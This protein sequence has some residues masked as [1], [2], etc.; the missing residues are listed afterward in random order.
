[1]GQSFL[2]DL[3]FFSALTQDELDRIRSALRTQRLEPWATLYREGDDA[4]ALFAVISGSVVL[5]WGSSEGDAETITSLAAGSWFGHQEVLDGTPR[6]F[7]CSADDQPVLLAML[8]R[9]DLNRFLMER[10]T[11]A[12]KL[13]GALGRDLEL[14]LRRMNEHLLARESQSEEQQLATSGKR[15]ST[16]PPRRSSAPPKRREDDMERISVLVPDAERRTPIK[17]RY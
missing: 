13:L 4:S 3:P 16:K 9:T 6:M 17:K 8:E 10:G 2:A 5:S 1:M 7:T 12:L 15:R 14:L 11:L